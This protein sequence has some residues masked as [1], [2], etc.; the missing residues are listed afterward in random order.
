MERNSTIALVV[1]AAVILALVYVYSTAAPGAPAGKYDDF[2]QCLTQKGITMY[3]TEWC[4]KCKE[5]K[6]FFGTSFDHVNYMNCDWNKEMCRAIGVSGYPTWVIDG[7]LYPGKV[8]LEEL[9]SMSGC[10]LE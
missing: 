5:Q 9:S 4:S 10:G 8:T 3:G 2:A 6:A 7:K 1:A